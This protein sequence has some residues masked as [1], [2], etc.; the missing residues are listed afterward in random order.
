MKHL[1]RDYVIIVYFI[2]NIANLSGP[3]KSYLIDY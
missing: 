2:Y 1:G 3:K